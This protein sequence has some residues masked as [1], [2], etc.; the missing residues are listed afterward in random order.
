[1]KRTNRISSAI[2]DTENINFDINSVTLN[3]NN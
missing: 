3:L 2:K 1:M